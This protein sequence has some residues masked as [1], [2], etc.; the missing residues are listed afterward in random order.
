MTR[1]RLIPLIG[2]IALA[3]L[4]AWWWWVRPEKVDMAMYAPAHSLLYIESNN[5]LRIVDSIVSTPAWKRLAPELGLESTSDGQQWYRRFVRWTGLG[6]I[7]SVILSRSQVA[8]VVTELGTNEVGQTLNIR[9]EA[10]LLIETHT[11][12]RRIRPPIEDALKRIATTTYGGATSRRIVVDGIEL[13]EWVSP[14]G[15]RR[16]VAA[17]VGSLVIVGNSEQAVQKC[18][19]VAHRREPSLQEDSELQKNRLA[20]NA[21]GALTYGYVPARNSAR[22]VSV[23][24]PLLLG[25]TPDEAQ[26]QRLISAA[27][28]KMFGSMAWSSKSISSGIEDR[29]R[30]SLSPSVLQPLK[31]SFQQLATDSH[32]P[33]VLPYGFYSITFYSFR[34]P[35]AAWQSLR[36]SVSSTTDALSAI[37]FSSVLKAALLPYG[38]SQPE[39]FLSAVDG[40]MLT[41]RLDQSGERALLVARISNPS[42]MRDVLTKK[43]GFSRQAGEE[44]G[45]ELFD[46]AEAEAS[47]GLT[48]QLVFL[49][50]PP[51]VL[52]YMKTL[53]DTSLAMTNDR[54]HQVTLLNPQTQRTPIVSYTSDEDRIRGLFAAIASIRGTP[55]G[56]SQRFDKGLSDI[57]YAVTETTL[58]DDGIDRVTRS[59][60]G[61]FSTL[62]MLL[63]SN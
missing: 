58:S 56:Q 24:L 42:A 11:L 19:A 43:L 17:F 37:F 30:I 15:S 16:L 28:S 48:Q 52:H 53:S 57:P 14:D 44:S 51:D 63:V 22:L 38:I 7:N 62:L 3:I 35:L 12:G 33:P 54:F 49:G 5:L 8:V 10:A 59:S 41:I 29:Y 1:T 32:Q 61:Q 4:I 21:E 26:S 18:L 23:G 9:P 2:F 6:P 34:N 45:V 25:R 31:P 20:L 55:L 36:T 60:F 27:A 47:A 40:D 46:F 13:N 50:P 39:E